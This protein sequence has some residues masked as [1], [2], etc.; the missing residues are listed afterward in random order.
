MKR[1]IVSAM[2]LAGSTVAMAEAPGGPNCG[3]GNMLFEGQS[4]LP[5]HIVASITN[6]TS[7]NATFGMTSGTNGCSTS[8]TLTYGGKEMI[9]VGALLDEFSED[10][11]RGDGE[12]LSAVA[13]SLG[14]SAEDRVVFK[15]A[16][17][18][19]FDKIFPSA[20]VTTEHVLASMWSVMQ[21]DAQLAKYAS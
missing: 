5:S 1:I 3:W 8:G 6:G 10:V 16:M 21:S 17:H 18:N 20:D 19:N 11:A 9:N 4:G 14:V 2:L 13:V 12:V 7:G 15:Q